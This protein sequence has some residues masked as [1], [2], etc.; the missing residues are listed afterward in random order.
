[1]EMTRQA[2]KHSRQALNPIRLLRRHPVATCAGVVGAAVGLLAFRQW[3]DY[4]AVPVQ[5][6]P[7]PTL[8]AI[9]RVGQAVVAD[10]A[11]MIRN[12]VLG[13]LI[14]RAILIFQPGVRPVVTPP[15]NMDSGNGPNGLADD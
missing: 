6:R 13:G 14:S 4:Q 5:K 8:A 7:R 15:S 11:R 1:M 9:R 3:S 12:A 2:L 10:S